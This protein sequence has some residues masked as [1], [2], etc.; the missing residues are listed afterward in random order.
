ME[1]SLPQSALPK[2][3][4]FII[5]HNRLT[6]LRQTIDSI[7]KTI[8]TPYEI[9]IHDNKS[10]YGPLVHWLQHGCPY[11]VYFNKTNDLLDVR[12]SMADYFRKT[13]SA[14]RNYVVTDPDVELMPNDRGDILELSAHI[15][16]T[17]PEVNAVAPDLRLDDIPACYGL[18]N[19]VID[20]YRRSEPYRYGTVTRRLSDDAEQSVSIKW[21]AV[22]T[23]FAMYRRSFHF[24]RVNPA[25][26]LQAPYNARHL[27]WYI[28]TS[29]LT[30]EQRFYRDLYH[31]RWGHWSSNFLTGKLKH[32]GQ[33]ILRARR[34]AATAAT[35]RHHNHVNN[36]APAPI[37]F[38]KKS[39]KHPRPSKSRVV[40]QK[41][42]RPAQKKRPNKLKKMAKHVAQRFNKRM[43]R[44]HRTTTT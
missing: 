13:K 12:T 38:A 8:K 42:A 24:Q 11:K 2:V 41:T 34:T 21:H 44:I 35:Y 33:L 14:A 16:D 3:P 6:M 39:H 36:R 40:P 37:K 43:R 5:S 20:W 23:T 26:L 29:N 17:H 15:L 30:A 10:T 32:H 22:D 27:D 19:K 7:V 9:I 28:N 1:L 31:N 4:I 25:I 18:K